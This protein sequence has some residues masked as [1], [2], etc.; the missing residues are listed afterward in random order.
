MAGCIL[1]VDLCKM[2]QIDLVGQLIS[3]LDPNLDPE[4][5]IVSFCMHGFTKVGPSKVRH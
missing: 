4:V 5:Q 3:K 1:G 2:V